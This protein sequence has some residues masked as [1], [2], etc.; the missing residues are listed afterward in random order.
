MSLSSDEE[1]RGLRTPG[2][3]FLSQPMP[4]NPQSSISPNQGQ[5]VVLQSFVGPV[6]FSCQVDG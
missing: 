1:S 2:W 5:R 3:H 4:I 6:V